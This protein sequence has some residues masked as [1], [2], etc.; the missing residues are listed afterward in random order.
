MATVKI[1]WRETSPIKN[2]SK[3]VDIRTQEW[4]E[5]VVQSLVLGN[6]VILY[7]VLVVGG[8]FFL[9]LLD[10]LHFWSCLHF[11]RRLCVCGCLHFRAIFFG[12]F[13]IFGFISIFWSNF[14]WNYMIILHIISFT[15]IKCV[16]FIHHLWGAVV[17]TNGYTHAC[18]ATKDSCM[19]SLHKGNTMVD[20]W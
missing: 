16:S 2:I 3:R 5:R 17:C 1:F 7:L 11:W 13:F 8:I 15:L 4:N 12:I 18:H 19:Q 10:L 20:Q 6:V 9:H 14:G